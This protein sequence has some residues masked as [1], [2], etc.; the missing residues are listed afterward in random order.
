MAKFDLSF[1]A[2]ETEEEI[3]IGIEYATDL[4]EEKTIERLASHFKELVSGHCERPF[5]IHS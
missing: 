4:F 1:D 2:Y 3:K 5:S